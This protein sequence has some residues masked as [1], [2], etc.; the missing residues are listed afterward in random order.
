MHGMTN[1]PGSGIEEFVTQTFQYIEAMIGLPGMK[2]DPELL[3]STIEL[4]CDIINVA[5]G[6]S[7][8]GR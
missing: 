6:S 8:L 5:C 7:Y 4:Y 3:T 2:V 1:R